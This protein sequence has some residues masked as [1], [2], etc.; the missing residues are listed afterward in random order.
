[1]G[2][3]GGWFWDFLRMAFRGRLCVGVVGLGLG[4]FLGFL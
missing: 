1:M 4:V 2:C 3:V